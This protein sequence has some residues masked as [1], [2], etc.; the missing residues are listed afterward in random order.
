[1]SSSERQRLD[2]ERLQE[3]IEELRSGLGET[4]EALAHKADVSARVKERGAAVKDEAIERGLELTQQA[5]DRGSELSGRVREWYNDVQA[6]LPAGSSEL[7]QQALRAVERA[8]ESARQMPP[9]RW[10]KLAAAGAGL[11]AMS[12]IVRR[13]RG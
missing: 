11:L 13:V 3:E 5:V 2:E 10:V 9:E 7:V 4:V 12:V 8:R 1:M 6:Q